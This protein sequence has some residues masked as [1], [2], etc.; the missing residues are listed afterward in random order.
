M[1]TLAD[2][3]RRHNLWGRR[4]LPPLLLLTDEAR[5]SNPFPVAALLPA[6]S[7]VILRHYQD[8]DRGRLARELAGFCRERGLLFLVGGDA[9]LAL[10]VG[11]DGLHLPEARMKGSLPTWRLWRK[12]RWLV[13]TAVHSWPAMLRAERL[14]ADAVVLSPVFPTASHPG[15]MSLGM[16]RFAQ[17]CRASRLPVYA[18]GG[19]GAKVA[20]RVLAA[21]AAGFA[22]ISGLMNGRSD[23]ERTQP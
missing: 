12:K 23:G 5:L 14:G 15:R 6:G 4:E 10:S 9:A 8:P 20:P 17:W 16:I 21:G 7:G 22:G 2:V 11:A 19:I 13:T 18:L 1:A 3:V